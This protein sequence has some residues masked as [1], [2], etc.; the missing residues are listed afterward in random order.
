MAAGAPATDLTPQP[1]PFRCLSDLASGCPG[2]RRRVC[3]RGGGDGGPGE[4]H[5]WLC[6]PRRRRRLRAPSPTCRRRQGD[7]FPPSASLPCSCT[8][9]KT[10]IPGLGGSDARGVVTFKEVPP[11][12]SLGWWQF[13]LVGGRSTA[14]WLE[15]VV[16][17]RF[18]SKFSGF[19]LSLLCHQQ[20]RRAFLLLLECWFPLSTMFAFV[21][22]GDASWWCPGQAFRAAMA[23]V[24]HLCSWESV[25]IV[26]R[27]GASC[28][29][30]G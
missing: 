22:L 11:S 24:V 19:S 10:Q 26:R 9:V 30:R 17:W 4:I 2:R 25:C 21:E 7:P 18:F 14:T 20:P 29:A 3:G 12:V 13:G 1:Q 23:S 27:I 28:Q 16:S 15:L 5:G 6:R 8:G